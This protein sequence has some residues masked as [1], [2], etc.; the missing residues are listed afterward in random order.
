MDTIEL[1]V[2]DGAAT[3]LLNRPDS[4]NA[5][6]RQ[7]GADLLEAVR[8]VTDDPEVRAV[9]IRGAG[10]AFSSGADLRDMAEQAAEAGDGA[11]VDVEA[12]LRDRYHPIITGLRTMP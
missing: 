7:F 3:I 9:V 12:M 8:T 4:L 6:N 1:T 5:W 11:S 10:R 2:D